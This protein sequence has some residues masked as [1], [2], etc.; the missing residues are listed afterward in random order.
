MPQNSCH[1]RSELTEDDR[2]AK[3]TMFE[4]YCDVI[5][6][7]RSKIELHYDGQPGRN[8]NIVL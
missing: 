8:K 3:C 7:A 2:M 5:P 1:F 6:S 4:G